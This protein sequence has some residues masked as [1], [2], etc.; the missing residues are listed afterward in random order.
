MSQIAIHRSLNFLDDPD[1]KTL[2]EIA[3]KVIQELWILFDD[4]LCGSEQDIQPVG[5]LLTSKNML[6][7]RSSESFEGVDLLNGGSEDLLDATAD[8]E[9]HTGR[10]S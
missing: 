2:S 4:L 3:F 8:Q 1:E 9:V 5:K 7:E 10:E 6:D